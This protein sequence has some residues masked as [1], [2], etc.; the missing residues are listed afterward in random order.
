MTPV[1]WAV[2]G[3]REVNV[4]FIEGMFGVF[5][6]ELDRGTKL[7]LRNRAQ[8]ADWLAGQSPEQARHGHQA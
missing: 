4:A 7:G 5:T 3:S 1:M 2:S 6:G 8:V